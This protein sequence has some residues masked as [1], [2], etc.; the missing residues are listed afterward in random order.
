MGVIVIWILVHQEI[1]K[2][3]IGIHS[4]MIWIV[5]YDGNVAYELPPF[6]NSS[7]SR[8]EQKNGCHPWI[9]YV[10]CTGDS[11]PSIVHFSRCVGHLTCINL[12]Y[13]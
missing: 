12:E 6:P 5:V 4:F 9:E 10:T 1:L 8:M 7:M 11:F 2:A 3:T 13:S